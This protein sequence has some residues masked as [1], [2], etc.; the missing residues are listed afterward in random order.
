MAGYTYLWLSW[1]LWII[2]TFFM[3]KSRRRTFLASWILLT[4]IGSRLFMIID[5]HHISFAYMSV[6]CGAFLL[7][8]KS[9]RWVYHLFASLTVMIGYTA[10]LL[11]EY[12]SP[13]WMFLPRFVMIPFLCSFLILSLVKGFYNQLMTGLLGICAGELLYSLM[14]SS[15]HLH[16]PVGDLIFLDHILLTMSSLF[17]MYLIKVARVKLIALSQMTSQPSLKLPE[18]KIL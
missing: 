13:I 6:I 2:V 3:R 1:I 12:T 11:W 7:H 18:E 17:F 8:S 4:M 5:H 10:I 16:K 14:L 9:S 15:Y